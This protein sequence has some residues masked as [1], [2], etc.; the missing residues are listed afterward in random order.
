LADEGLVSVAIGEL[1]LPFHAYT[2]SRA[3]TAYH[4]FYIAWDLTTNQ[5]LKRGSEIRD[6]LDW[7]FQ[8][9]QDV[10]AARRDIRARVIGLAI[11]G[12]PNLAAARSTLEAELGQLS[13]PF[14]SERP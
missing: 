9:W 1:T 10:R 11:Y 8:Q 4:V 13:H 14:P 2:F 7:F 6:P 3:G 5:P 12:S